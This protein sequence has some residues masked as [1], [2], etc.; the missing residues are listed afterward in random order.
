M[1]IVFDRVEGV[2]QPAAEAS[3]AAA[4]AAGASEEQPDPKALERQLEHIQRRRCRLQA[5]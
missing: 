4:E 2:V 5:D 1:P 3:P